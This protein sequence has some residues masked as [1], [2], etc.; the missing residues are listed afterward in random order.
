M[1]SPSHPRGLTRS[2]TRT[3]RRTSKRRTSKRR[4]TR[5]TTAMLHRRCH[6]TAESHAVERCSESHRS[7][8]HPQ[9]RRTRIQGPPRSS[10]SSM[11]RRRAFSRR[12]QS[13]SRRR[14]STTSSRRVVSSCQDKLLLLQKDLHDRMV[15]MTASST[16]TKTSFHNSWRTRTTST[17]KPVFRA[18]LPTGS[19]SSLVKARLA[20]GK[21]PHWSGSSR[22]RS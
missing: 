15:L 13:S 10:N 18:A 19:S 17:K 2:P 21:S 7:L 6:S 16:A 14:S 1:T 4:T 9:R 22:P 11:C 5:K 8:R 20:L 12:S 3:R